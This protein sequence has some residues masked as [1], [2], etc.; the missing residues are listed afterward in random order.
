M[1]ES[2]GQAKVDSQQQQGDAEELPRLL[3][4]TRSEMLT[5]Q[6]GAQPP[7]PP[8]KSKSDVSNSS[9]GQSKV[10][11]VIHVT[12]RAGFTCGRFGVCIDLARY[13]VH[14]PRFN[15]CF[16]ENPA[17]NKADITAATSI[18]Q[19]PHLCCADQVKAVASADDPAKRRKEKS[20][21]GALTWD[22]ALPLEVP[23]VNTFF[24]TSC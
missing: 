20:R 8:A 19:N 13:I 12:P 23:Q 24:A 16:N 5:S 9:L 18:Q 7:R 22:V 21:D 6:A 2:G 17:Q 10:N 1:A 14:H 4:S 11:L 3:G 15:I